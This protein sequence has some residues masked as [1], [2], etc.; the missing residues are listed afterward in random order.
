MGPAY[1]SARITEVTHVK[2]EID[3]DWRGMPRA[4]PF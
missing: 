2:P 4:D 1:V 3:M